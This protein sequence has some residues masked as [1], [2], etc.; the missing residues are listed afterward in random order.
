MQQ[1]F[2][3]VSSVLEM[4]WKSS[5]YI[6][7]FHFSTKLSQMTQHWETGELQTLKKLSEKN[8]KWKDLTKKS[9]PP[10]S[11]GH[12]Q[13]LNKKKYQLNFKQRFQDIRCQKAKHP[14]FTDI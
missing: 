13:Q 4:I 14:I 5:V 7:P 3:P 2:E 12:K 11:S 6:K 8:L 10:A 9:Q 1:L